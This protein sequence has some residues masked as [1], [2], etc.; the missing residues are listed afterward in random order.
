[1]RVW[2]LQKDLEE[3]KQRAATLGWKEHRKGDRMKKEKAWNLWQSK[4]K[5]WK[6]SN[7]Q[8]RGLERH[9]RVVTFRPTQEGDR[10]PAREG[11]VSSA[12]G[13]QG[14]QPPHSLCF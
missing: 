4:K 13:T 11:Y 10:D 12:I 7:T 5:R 3:H 1:M 14:K 9:W 6:I 2:N 8:A